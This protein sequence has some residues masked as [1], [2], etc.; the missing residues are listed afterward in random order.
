MNFYIEY[1]SP[2]NRVS[3]IV[4]IKRGDKMQQL[5]SREEAES[6]AAESNRRYKPLQYAVKESTAVAQ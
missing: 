3:G 6:I 2:V 1:F 5:F 4:S